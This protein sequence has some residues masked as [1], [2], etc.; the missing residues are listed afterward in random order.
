MAWQRLSVQLKG[1]A[2]PID[3]QTSARDWAQVTLDP[4]RARPI[5]LLFQVTHLALLRLD[6]DVPRDFGGFLEVLDG[7]PE[8]IEEDATVMDPTQNVPSDG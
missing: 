6:H 1:E 7:M 4:A 2:E 5:E 3:V 8:T